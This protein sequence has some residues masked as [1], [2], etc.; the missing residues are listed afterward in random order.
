MRQWSNSQDPHDIHQPNHF[1]SLTVAKVIN[2]YSSSQKLHVETLK[3]LQSVYAVSLLLQKDLNLEFCRN[4]YTKR[5]QVNLQVSIRAGLDQTT[6]ITQTSLALQKILWNPSVNR[7]INMIDNYSVPVM[8][9]NTV[10]FVSDWQCRIFLQTTYLIFSFNCPRSLYF[11]PF[12]L[13]KY[14]MDLTSRN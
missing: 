5:Q 13:W 11:Q 7:N 12:G 2:V 4:M 14:S 1:C 3:L 8:Y 9:W 6:C 10:L